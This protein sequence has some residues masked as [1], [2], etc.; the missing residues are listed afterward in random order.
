VDLA[1]AAP[2]AQFLEVTDLDILL[3]RLEN[4]QRDG[5]NYDV[6]DCSFGFPI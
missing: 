6:R 3:A 4:D 2:P 1:P 5:G